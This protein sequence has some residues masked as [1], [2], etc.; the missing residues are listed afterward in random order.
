MNRTCIWCGASFSAPTSR[1]RYC[2]GAHRAAA[3]KARA[4]G[5]WFPIASP[6]SSTGEIRT[7]TEAHLRGSGIDAAH[8]LWPVALAVADQLD[9][10]N[11][12]SAALP[13]VV[14]AMRNVLAMI[15]NERNPD[16]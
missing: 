3:S 16:D 8:W 10:P 2:S 7:A 9:D 6:R 15:A 11:T 14:D 4:A 12:S 5:R 13:R 1:A